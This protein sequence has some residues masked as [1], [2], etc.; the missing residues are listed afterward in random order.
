MKMLCHLLFPALSV[1]FAV[2]VW[3]PVVV[4]E[5]MRDQVDQSPDDWGVTA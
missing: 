5:I 2:K 1:A 4:I 3:A